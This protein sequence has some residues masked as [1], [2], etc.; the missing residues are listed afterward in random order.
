MLAALEGEIPDRLPATVHQWQ[1]YH[2][3]RYMG[4]LSDIEAFR[5]LRLDAAITVQDVYIP[6]RDV[7]WDVESSI[8]NTEYGTTITAYQISTPDGIL[9]KREEGNAQTTWTIEPLLKRPEEMV[10]IQKYLPVPKMDKHAVRK[11]R[12]ELDQDGILR[13][14]VF[15]EQV[16]SW[17]QACCLYGTE[18][19]IYAT[20]DDPAW[21]HAFL[22]ALNEK[23]LQYID[24]SLG[25]GEF[26]LIETGGGAG[27]SSV[28]SPTIFREFCL[29]YD[30]E[31]HDALHQR[32]YKVVY[33]TC[34]GMMAILDLILQN[35]CD[36]SE[37]LTP[38]SMGGDADHRE[39]KRRIGE[40][41]CLIGGMDQH[42]ILTD[43]TPS[44]IRDEVHRLYEDLG[45]G[46]R[47]IMSAC[48]H[49]FE[50]P[51]ENL[52]AYAQAAKECVY[53]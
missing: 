46:G 39:I 28:I 40:E 31:L 38:P 41:V 35:G 15:G 20:Y 8:H 34:G 42:T 22:H 53:S 43:G 4:G 29:P 11:T 9:T 33:H 1:P 13:G 26:D 12:L 44:I 52:R 30:L 21:V 49:F 27:S 18:W 32:G 47:Y 3:Q 45:Q 6:E 19:M 10:L 2:L 48:D 14:F 36:A 7:N 16:G 24:E 23:K 51:V 17:Q 37:T 50:A 5:S 25:G